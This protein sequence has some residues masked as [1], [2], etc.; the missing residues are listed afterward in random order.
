MEVILEISQ[1]DAER[2]HIKTEKLTLEELKKKLAMAELVESLK[3][4]HEIAKQYGIDNWTMEEI[5]N[6]IQEAKTNNDK[7]SD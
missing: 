3:E 2:L 7:N 4:S 5:N 1:E 6:L